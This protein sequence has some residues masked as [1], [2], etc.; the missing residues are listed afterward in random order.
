[1]MDLLMSEQLKLRHCAIIED[2]REKNLI[3]AMTDTIYDNV[4]ASTPKLK[5]TQLGSSLTTIHIFCIKQ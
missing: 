4:L 3:A 2:E 1:M 5:P